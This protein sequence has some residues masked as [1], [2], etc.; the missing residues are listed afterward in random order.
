MCLSSGGGDGGAAAAQ[1]AEEERKANI[2]TGQASIDD[3]FKKFDDPYY[4]KQHQ[5]YL[6]FAQPQVDRQSKEAEQ[7]LGFGLVRQGIQSSTAAAKAQADLGYQIGTANQGV[8]DQAT[9]AEGTA[10]SQVENARSSLVAQLNA[11]ANAGAA[12]TGSAARAATLSLQPT[13]SPIGTLF[14]NVTG[15]LAAAGRGEGLFTTANGGVGNYGPGYT[16]GTTAGT[17]LFNGGSSAS[18]G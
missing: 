2:A 6:D 1:K 7:Q 4:A 18:Y 10:R 13:F 15:N 9:A 14:S 8:E 17:R 3:Q 16:A 11:D 12:A 5:A